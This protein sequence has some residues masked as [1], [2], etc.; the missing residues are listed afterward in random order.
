MAEPMSFPELEEQLR[1]SL[2]Q[3]GPRTE[4]VRRLEQDLLERAAHIQAGRHVVTRGRAWRWALV[5]LVLVIVLSVLVVGPANLAAAMQQLLSYIPGIG[6]VQQSAGLRVLAEPVS[7][8]REGIT[9]TIEQAVTD[10][11]RTIVVM[12]VDGIPPE[13]RP[14]GEDAAACYENAELLAAAGGTAM[15]RDGSGDDARGGEST[16]RGQMMSAEGGGWGSGYEWRMVFAAIPPEVNRV[17]MHIPCLDGTAPGMAPEDWLLELHFIP[18]PPETTVIPVLDITPVPG[19]GAAGAG[20]QESGLVLERVI[21]L[22]DRYILI[23]SFRQRQDTPGMVHGLAG[24]PEITIAGGMPWAWLYPS[25]VDVSSSEPGAFPWAFQVAKGFRGPL[26]I[27]FPVVSVEL[28]VEAFFQVDVG[29]NPAVGQEWEVDEAFR[30]GGHAVR[31]VALRRTERGYELHFE[32]DMSVSGVSVDALDGVVTGGWGGGFHGQTSAGFEYEAPVPTGALRFR[33]TRMMVSVP[34]PWTLTWS[35]PPGGVPVTPSALLQLSSACLTLQRL[36]EILA[37]P[38]AMPEDLTGRL[39]VYG[40]IRDDGQRLSPENAGVFVM[41]AAT[42]ARKVLGPGTWPDLSADGR[43]GAYSGTTDGLHVVDLTTGEERLVPG[44][45]ANDYNPR[46][47]PDGGWLAFRR[48][49]DLNLYRVR[50][51]GSGLERLTQGPEYELLLDWSADGKGVYYGFPSAGGVT[52]R[53]LDLARRTA[54]DLFTIE[55]KD[56]WAAISPDG[57]RIAYIARAPGAIGYGLYLARLDG[58]E[59]RLLV[60]LDH[61]GITHPVW[62]PDGRWLLVTVVNADRVQAENLPALIDPVTCQVVPL[63]GIEGYVQDWAR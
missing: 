5:M 32:T 9:V 14:R 26:T 12:R 11:E 16:W 59:A 44:T 23:G 22:D 56:A 20:I 47:S 24:E 61:W 48:I 17:T 51:D 53:Y 31:V 35:P 18:A 62:S 39:I 38:P 1:R 46:W 27:S 33:V 40:R 36:Q 10:G 58:S 45:T 34:G 60:Q 2:Q 4:F 52:L 25:D 54:H 50:Y 57:E 41:D 3:P 13:A 28:P 37:Q 21:E 49:D 8:E 30:L 7:L 43:L 29:A 15:N 19:T 42:G 63:T 6:L 55:A